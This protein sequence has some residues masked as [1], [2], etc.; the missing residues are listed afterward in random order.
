[1]TRVFLSLALLL[2]GC[3]GVIVSVEREGCA[4]TRDVTVTRQAG[5]PENTKV[6]VH[7]E[8]GVQPDPDPIGTQI[9][10]STR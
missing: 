4:T 2:A 3:T 8:C 7:R 5:A 9:R 1:M 6:S 10:K